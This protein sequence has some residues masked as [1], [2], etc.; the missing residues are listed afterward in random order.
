MKLKSAMTI[1]NKECEFLG[2]TLDELI[3]DINKCEDTYPLKSIEAYTVYEKS[4]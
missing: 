1:L 2:K 4:L 3:E